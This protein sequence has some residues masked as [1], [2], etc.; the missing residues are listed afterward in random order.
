M[1]KIVL[2][3]NDTRNENHHGCSR[4]MNAID[5]NIMI[6]EIDTVNYI[7]LR[8]FWEKDENIKKNILNSDLVLINGEGTLHDDSLYVNSLC[9][10][11]N[12]CFHYNIP[13]FIVNA[14]ISNLSLENL[15][16]I[17][18]SNMIYVRDSSSCKYLADHNIASKIVPDL[19]FWMYR[20]FDIFSNEKKVFGYTDS[21]VKQKT[22]TLEN[23]A[24]VNE[25]QFINIF[26]NNYVK[27][28]VINCNILNFISLARKK[29][30][31]NIKNYFLNKKR[32]NSGMYESF[33]HVDFI[34]SLSKYEFI[35]TGR[36][37][38]VCFCLIMK[39]PFYAIPSNTY[40]IESL[41]NDIGLENHKFIMSDNKNYK[42]KNFYF[43]EEELFN[44]D[45]FLINADIEINNMFN[46]I[47]TYL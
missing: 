46:E 6:R 1:K 12:F 17:K 20:S 18:K 24:K 23:Y 42:I 43:T 4:V 11:V 9:S 30:K 45:K 25:L 38:M 32:K 26:N 31:K 29:Y 28:E 36:Y 35:V 34:Q 8:V 39:I 2:V 10:L 5:K 16:K 33:D 27:M 7:S 13:I 44:I 37:H 22:K 19:T 41:L 40:K 15:N 14:T 21:V 47:F 3:A